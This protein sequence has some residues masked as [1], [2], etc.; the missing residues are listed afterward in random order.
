[1]KRLYKEHHSTIIYTV[2]KL[3]RVGYH[4]IHK[5]LFYYIKKYLYNGIFIKELT[6]NTL[7]ANWE[8]EHNIKLPYYY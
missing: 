2:D 3:G 6:Y 4:K 8:F 5:S 1:M 7:K